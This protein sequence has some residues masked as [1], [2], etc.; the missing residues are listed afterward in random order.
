MTKKE[1]IWWWI[2]FGM[3]IVTEIFFSFA[4]LAISFFTN[5]V[6]NGYFSEV[7][8]NGFTSLLIDYHFFLFHPMYL[9]FFLIVEWLGALGLL[10]MSIRIKSKKILTVLLLIILLCLSYLFIYQHT[11]FR[12]FL[13]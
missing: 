9:L 11:F 5:G 13:N 10:I 2:F 8:V 4:Y 7:L 12:I 1:K 6:V 3:F